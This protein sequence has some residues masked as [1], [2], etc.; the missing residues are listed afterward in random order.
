MTENREEFRL[1]VVEDEIQLPDRRRLY[2]LG[3]AVSKETWASSKRHHWTGNG[4]PSDGVG[5]GGP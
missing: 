2:S 4:W 3:T 5:S 1:A